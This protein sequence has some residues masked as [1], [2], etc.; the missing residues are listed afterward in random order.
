MNQT[1]KSDAGKLQLT[2]VPTGIIRA[3][4]RIRMYGNSK[5][6]EGGPDNWKQVEPSRY[7]D[8]LFRHLL[9]YFDDPKGRRAQGIRKQ[10]QAAPGGAGRADK[11]KH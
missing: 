11:E 1:A 4:A 5:Y 7:R 10:C 3:I 6:P 9:A 8:A 2:L